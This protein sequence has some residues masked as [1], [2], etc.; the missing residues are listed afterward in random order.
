MSPSL[1]AVLLSLVGQADP[2]DNP[3][4]PTPRPGVR[5]W[6]GTDREMEG[7]SLEAERRAEAG[8]PLAL[9]HLLRMSNLGEILDRHGRVNNALGRILASKK[10]DPLARAQATF[11]AAKQDRLRGALGSSRQRLTELGLIESAWVIG[12]FDN[13]AGAG[14]QA[15]YPPEQA[16]AL[17]EPVAGKDRKVRWLPSAELA[18]TGALVIS[19][20]IHPGKEATAYAL[21]AVEADQETRAALRTGS[22]DALKAFLNGTEVLRIDADRRAALDQDAAPIVIPKGS[23]TLLLK[24]S[25][26]GRAAR[27]YARL[28]APDG[29]PLQGVRVSAER[30]AVSRALE[31]QKGRR[32]AAPAKHEVQTVR[33]AIDRAIDKYGPQSSDAL[34]ELYA[35]RSNLAAVLN[36]Y[37]RRKLPIPP[38]Q[39]LVRALTKAPDDPWS[40][41]LYGLRVAATDRARATSALEAALVVDPS[42]APALERLSN[43]AHQ[44]ER[45]LAARAALR[46]ALDKDPSFDPARIALAGLLLAQPLEAARGRALLDEVS[47]DA[48]SPALSASLARVLVD[49]GDPA[50]GLALAERTLSKSFDNRSLRGLLVRAALDRA[51]LDRALAH[52]EDAIRLEPHRVGHRL[53]RAR[54]LAAAGPGPGL[55]RALSTLSG[56]QRS[57]PDAPS[58]PRL[59]AELCLRAQDQAGAKQA[60]SRLVELSPEDRE[61]RR[62]LAALSGGRGEL[63]DEFS[64]DPG[65]LLAQAP[66]TMEETWGASVLF[67]RT[68]VRLL[69]NGSSSRFVQRI[70]RLQKPALADALRND[71]VQFSPSRESAEILSAEIIRPSG[72]IL[73]AARIGEDGPRGK[74]GGQYVDLREKT[75]DFGDIRPG[76][77]VH[78][79]Y[80]VDSV[81]P[82]IFGGFFGDMT[83]IEGPLPKERVEVIAMAPADRPLYPGMIRNPSPEVSIEGGVSKMVWRKT[84]VH[85]IEPEPLSPP[86]SELGT[87]VSVSTYK[88]WED[89]AAWYAKLFRDQMELDD[90][91]RQAGRRAVEGAKDEAEKIRRL[92]DYV[93]KST[94]YVGI[95]LGIHGWKPFLASE[96]HRRRYGDCKDKATLLAALL[97]DNGIEATIALVRTFDRGGFPEGHASMWAFNHAITYVPSAELFLDGTA[98]YSGSGELPYQDQGAFV[99]IVWPDGHYRLDS[100]PEATAAE[101]M[102]RSSY[103]A[104]LTPDGDL[105]LEG[106]EKFFGARA[107][108]LRQEFEEPKTRKQE[109]E[110]ALSQVAPGAEVF[111]FEFSDL[112]DLERSPSYRYRAG[113][114]RYAAVQGREMIMPLTLFPHEVTAA[115]GALSER[116]TDLVTTFGWSTRNVIRYKLPP[117]WHVQ[118]LPEGQ[119]VSTPYLSLSQSITPTEDGFITDDTVTLLARRVPRADYPAFRQA[120]TAVDRALERKVVLSR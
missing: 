35:L 61:A 39:D 32:P 7:L 11:M 110:H 24:V 34:S 52:I 38:I 9:V 2:S 10:L 76:D 36:L 74:I 40:W 44:S 60:L 99:L 93:V 103:Q 12:P 43:L 105:V 15:A 30:A 55:V 98:E 37:D 83:G 84:D 49:Q 77:L 28:T 79:R 20:L 53:M 75:I 116:K 4:L 33:T 73:K 22:T 85:P 65:P 90:D 5:S 56:D 66:S 42:F 72:E 86:L 27:L 118:A 80:R 69:D 57:F 100:P 92:Y 70:A 58:I 41:T 31:A 113:L 94:R 25:W 50:R 78:L 95:E 96:V 63:E 67:E 108:P 87:T 68:A 54:V 81:G 82:N 3:E 64:I 51:E 14:L 26:S 16:I 107:A 102:N 97:R 48:A 21:V 109:L 59:L 112:S 120:L 114:P 18:G 47:T 17:D 6:P 115:Y 1:L 13:A 111:D 106:E 88:S 101:N 89:L 117:G 71:A 46:T 45:P 29:G 104:Q 8:D 119:T 62:Q 91:A 19:S 23:S